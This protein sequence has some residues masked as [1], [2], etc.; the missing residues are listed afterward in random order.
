MLVESG[1]ELKLQTAWADEPSE[2]N[3]EFEEPRG[4]HFQKSLISKHIL[5]QYLKQFFQE[6]DLIISVC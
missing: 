2:Q 5:S 6:E 1:K 4:I 3:N